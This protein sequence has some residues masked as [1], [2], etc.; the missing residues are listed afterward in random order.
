MAGFRPFFSSATGEWIE[1]TTTAED[2]DGHLLGFSWR[3][4]PGVVI[5]EHIHSHQEE[6]FIITAGQGACSRHGETRLPQQ[7]Q[8]WRRCACSA[9]R[10]A[11]RR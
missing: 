3:S 11:G 6:R 10:S 9:A 4:V 5:T 7:R 8:R 2:S 1:F